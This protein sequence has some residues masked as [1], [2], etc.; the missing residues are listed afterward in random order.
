MKIVTNTKEIVSKYDVS[1]FDF[2]SIFVTYKILEQTGEAK[3]EKQGLC[4]KTE[5][6]S[7][8][9]NPESFESEGAKNCY[10][11]NKKVLELL[12]ND[13]KPIYDYR[14]LLFQKPFDELVSKDDFNDYIVLLYNPDKST[15]HKYGVKFPLPHGMGFSYLTG[16]TNKNYDLN[17]VY[18]QLKGRKDIAFQTKDDKV[19]RPIPFYAEAADDEEYYI[20]FIWQP[21]DE[22]WEKLC[23]LQ[24]FENDCSFSAKNI[25][26]RE[27][28]KINE[29]T[30]E[31][32]T[33]SN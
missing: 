2:D 21:T 5:V 3:R 18:E 17:A 10:L 31:F 33:G 30:D 25:V 22:D 11:W 19:I 20:G 16:L 15:W 8:I 7:L 23:S 27:F 29:R 24:F 14:D 12:R 4:L 26:F 1:Y 6:N 32:E 13:I 9:A 28:L